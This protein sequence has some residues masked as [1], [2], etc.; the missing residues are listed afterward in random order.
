MKR[1]DLPFYVALASAPGI[2]PVRFKVLLKHFKSAQ[3]VW[4]APEATLRKIFTSELSNK[5]IQY[6]NN[7]DI[8]R[9]IEK[10]GKLDIKL[11]TLLDEGYPK[12]LKEIENSPPVL[13]VKGSLDF[14]LSR[15]IAVVGTRKMTTYGR[16]VTQALVEQ[17]VK[18]GFVVVS[19]LARGVDAFAHRTTVANRG[20]T[21]AVL[22]G[23]L[24][25]FYPPEN[26]S[27]ADEIA[28]GNGAVISE[29]PLDLPSTP[30]NFPARNR[31]ISGLSL[32]VLVT[33]AGEDSGSLITATIAGE[34]GR[35]VFAVPGPIYSKLSHGPAQL[36]KQGAKLVAKVEDILEEL[37]LNSDLR[38]RNSEK[39]I[40]AGSEEEQKIIDLLVQGP[41]HIDELARSSKISTAKLGSIISLMEISG[42]VKNLGGGSYSLNT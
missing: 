31:I 7:F 41:V 32:G 18:Q 9:Y 35:E 11:I 14:D 2:G 42:K 29:F 1:K 5:F 10:I 36:I 30:G 40:E 23:G 26:I 27:L 39:R 24:N 28:S 20:K 3:A 17:L 8:T 22:G 33:E 4:N 25:K 12:L 16:Q 38:I 21:I 13:Y 34:Q 15:S 19:G 37:N 6:R